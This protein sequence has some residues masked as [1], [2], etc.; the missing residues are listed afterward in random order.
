VRYFEDFRVGDVHELG[1][2][3]ISEDEM[4]SF[5]RMY[6]PQ[7]RHVNRSG[8]PPIASGWHV[9][10]LFMRMYVDSVVHESAAD[11]SP[12]IDE[13]R[14]L[15]PVGPGDELVGRMTV[16]GAS[17]SLSRPDCGIV[18]QRGE[19]TDSSA[20]PVMRFVFYGLMRKRSGR[21]V[22][23]GNGEWPAR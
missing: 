14:W 10:S 15:R 20:R 18:R 8:E 1:S 21:A 12:G 22:L 23:T 5:A 4:V 9:A 16:I 13:L 19:L 11:V 6:D 2:V 7:P 3:R 17:P